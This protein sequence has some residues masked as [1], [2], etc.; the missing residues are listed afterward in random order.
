MKW[1][2]ELFSDRTVIRRA[3]HRTRTLVSWRHCA[4]MVSPC[5]AVGMAVTR[6]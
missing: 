1:S 3:G 6:G 4:A 5:I 2:I